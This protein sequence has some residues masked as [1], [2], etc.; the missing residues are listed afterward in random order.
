MQSEAWHL[1]RQG[2]EF[3]WPTQLACHAERSEASRLHTTRLLGGE[4]PRFRSGCPIKIWHEDATPPVERHFVAGPL[5][6]RWERAGYEVAVRASN[7]PQ[8]CRS[9]PSCCPASR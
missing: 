1:G 5:P 6:S 2:H 4:I 7:F 9:K 8:A 3:L